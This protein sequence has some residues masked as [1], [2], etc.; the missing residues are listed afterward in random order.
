VDVELVR[1]VG[2]DPVDAGS[3]WIASSTEPFALLVADWRR[4]ETVAKH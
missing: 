2:L 4:R 1:A 3:L